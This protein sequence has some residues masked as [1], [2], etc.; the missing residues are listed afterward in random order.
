MIRSH[1]LYCTFIS[2]AIVK[3][4]ESSLRN[5]ARHGCC[6][7]EFS[8]CSG[9]SGSQW[10]DRNSIASSDGT[11]VDNLRLRGGSRISAESR[12][13]Y[14]EQVYQICRKNIFAYFLRN[15]FPFFPI[16]IS[17][18]PKRP[19]VG[20]ELFVN[21]Q[22]GGPFSHVAVVGEDMHRRRGVLG[23]FGY[24]L[25]RCMGFEAREIRK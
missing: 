14:V 3:S 20:T 24:L 21:M 11:S 9:S 2:L 7:A 23:Q 18:N 16:G 10:C 25:W 6:T 8:Q 13:I 19:S 5:P 17:R 15:L 1:L 12:N 4:S 22:V